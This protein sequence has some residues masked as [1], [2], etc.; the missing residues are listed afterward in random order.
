[1][2]LRKTFKTDRQAEVDGV[3]V[4]VGINEHNGK[5]IQVRLSRMSRSNKRYQA[6]LERVTRP[7]SSAIQNESLDNELA[8][9][10]L[11]GVF[12]DTILMDW[13]N[14]P[15]SEL[16]GN[17]ED[18]ELLPFSRDNAMALFAEL[19]DLYEDWES[20]AKKASTFREAE[21]EVAAKN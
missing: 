10:M 8:T 4:D 11:Q 18:K 12:A 13:H 5:P 21:R 19:P 1:M 14:L 6:E 3:L 9:G 17:P 15:K 2:S 16:T 7:H 20:R